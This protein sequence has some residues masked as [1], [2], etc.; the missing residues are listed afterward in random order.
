MRRDWDQRARENARHYVA[1]LQNEW[2]DAEFFESGATWVRYYI[3]SSLAEICKGR[4]ASE[5]R[6]LEIGC[7][8]GRMTLPLSKIFGRVDAVDISPEMIA[9][10][11]AALRGSTNVHLH[12]NN[13]EDLSI[14]PDEQFDFVFSAIVFQHIPS[15]GI[16]ENYIQEAARVLKPQSLFK[17][18]VQGRPIEDR[19][20]NT[21]VGVSFTDEQLRTIAAR[22]K[23]DVK[24][25]Q[26][27]GTE[28]FWL[29]FQKR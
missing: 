11:Q 6:I 26:G 21:W 8:A 12:V 19:L 24:A 22:C 5:L 10:A 15:R 17:F 13:G 18:Q 16:V 9:R 4:P 25:T 7:G 1:T 23:F 29:T 2:T 20:A 3:D 27:V 28:E 14:F